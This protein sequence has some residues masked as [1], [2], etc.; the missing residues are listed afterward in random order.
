MTAFFPHWTKAAGVTI[1]THGF[2]LDEEYPAWVTAMADSIPNYFHARFP[3]LDSDCSTYKR[4]MTNIHGVF[5]Y[6]SPTRTN[7]RPPTVTESGEIIIELDW[8]SLSGDLVDPYASTYD[9]AHAVSEVLMATNSFPELNGHPA[10]E[11]PIHLVG[12]SRG[13]SLMSQLS[14]DLGTNGIWTDQL[15]TLDP[16]PFNNDGNIDPALYDDASAANTYST[17]LYADNYWQDLGPGWLVGDPDGESVVGAYVR[18]LYSLS[19][20]YG[21]DHENVHLWYHGTIDWDTPATDTGATITSTQ[22]A[23]WWVNYEEEGTNAGFEYSLMGGGNRMS[24]VEPVGAGYSAICDGYNQR[25]NFGAGY[26]GNRTVLASNRGTWPNLIQCNVV[27]NTI[28]TA[29]QTISTKFYYQYC[30]ASSSVTTQ[31][32]FGGDFN[33]YNTNSTSIAE[34]SLTNTG[35]N[36][37]YYDTVNLTTTHVPPGVYAIYGKISDGTHTRYLYAPQLVEIVPS[38]TP[39]VLG[40]IKRNGSQ[41]VIGVSGVSGQKIVIQSSPDLH[42]WLPLATNTLTSGTW[43]YTNNAPQN[44]REEFYRAFLMP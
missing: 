2:E 37:V 13:G 23:D 20:G 28:V 40:A 34:I 4:T 24:T 15:T 17:V 39:P 42:N 9:V 3:G 38:Q 5:Y 32:Y 14:Y 11:F 27:G 22:R 44:A 6:Y 12:H 25:W 36:A 8:T 18:Q 29:G 1:I 33:P 21:N 19:G 35:V 41:F 30:G 10:I 7:G 16:Y 26:S 31:F 43:N